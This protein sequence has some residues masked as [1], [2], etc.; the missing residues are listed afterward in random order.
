MLRY[1]PLLAAWLIPGRFLCCGNIRADGMLW[2]ENY[3]LAAYGIRM[4]SLRIASQHETMIES[5]G[6]RSPAKESCERQMIDRMQFL[7]VLTG[8]MVFSGLYFPVNRTLLLYNDFQRCTESLRFHDTDIG[9]GRECGVSVQQRNRMNTR[10][11]R[12]AD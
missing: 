7:P 10:C 6:L 1:L 5:C 8:I 9:S 11:L 2:M 3:L 12:A 4:E